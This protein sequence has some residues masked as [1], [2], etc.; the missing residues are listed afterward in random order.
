MT[1]LLLWAWVFSLPGAV[2]HRARRPGQR[3]CAGYA[4]L[5]G[6]PVMLIV[7]LLA[8]IGGGGNPC[9]R[10][11]DAVPAR[12]GLRRARRPAQ[13]ADAG[14]SRLRRHGWSTSTR[15]ATW[16][17]IPAGA[18]SSSTSTCSSPH[19]AAGAG[20]QPGR[21]ADWLDRR[22][23]LELPAD[24]VLARQPGTLGAGLQ[25]LAANA[26]GDAALL[27]AAALCRRAAA[28]W[29]RSARPRAPRDWAAPSCLGALLISSPPRP[30]P[31]R[32]RCTSGCP[33]PWPARR[34]SAR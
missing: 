6:P 27:L 10:Q 25:A 20:R 9:H 32:G 33:T 16:P 23:H 34:R 2:P 24:L 22:R 11:L 3:R 12:H 13:R 4:S 21:A 7:A 14:D 15:S 19:G 29:S 18:A 28:R 1:G 8:L 30:S 31:P 5:A 26:I 17:T